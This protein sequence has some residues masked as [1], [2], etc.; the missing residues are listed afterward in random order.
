MTIAERECNI[1]SDQFQISKVFAFYS[2]KKSSLDTGHEIQTFGDVDIFVLTIVFAKYNCISWQS[3]G[4]FGCW[5]R[6][7][8]APKSGQSMPAGPGLKQGR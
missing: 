5:S 8:Q 7:P 4:S 2:M 3:C 6:P 1:M